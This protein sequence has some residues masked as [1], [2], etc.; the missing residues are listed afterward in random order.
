MFKQCQKCCF[1]NKCIDTWKELDGE[2]MSRKNI[3]DLN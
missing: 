3:I 2:E 1:P